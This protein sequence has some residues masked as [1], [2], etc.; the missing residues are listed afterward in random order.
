MSNVIQFKARQKPPPQELTEVSIER[1]FEGALLARYVYR[2]E[3]AA[4]SL[5][6]EVVDGFRTHSTL[7]VTT[8]NPRLVDIV[9]CDECKQASEKYFLMRIRGEL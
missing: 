5:M 8:A 3:Q 6:G 1:A 7:I 4:L 9:N 2:D